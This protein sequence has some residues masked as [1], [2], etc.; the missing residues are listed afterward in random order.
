MPQPSD[1]RQS[2]LNPNLPSV[3]TTVSSAERT[4]I[5][6]SFVI[7]GEVS[8]AEPLYIEGQIEGSIDFA[9]HSVT[10]GGNGTVE[11]NINAREVVIL[12]KVQGNIQCTDRVDI[13]SQGSLRGDVVTPRISVQDGASLEGSVH[14]SALEQEDNSEPAKAKQASA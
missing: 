14:V 6:R 9:G 8:G 11:A 3:K 12:G 4:A 1:S 2:P 13:R 5:G 7:R 10:I